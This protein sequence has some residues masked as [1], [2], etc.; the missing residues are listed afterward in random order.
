MYQYMMY[1]IT[2]RLVKHLVNEY[3][4]S[5]VHTVRYDNSSNLQGGVLIYRVTFEGTEREKTVTRK[6]ILK[7]VSVKRYALFI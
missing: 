7:S 6:M 5:G 1:D 4:T 3:Q 2:G